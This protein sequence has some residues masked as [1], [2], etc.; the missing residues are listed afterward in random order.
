[1]D[2]VIINSIEKIVSLYNEDFAYYNDFKYVNWCDVNTWD[3]KECQLATKE[4]INSYFNQPRFFKQLN[5]MD[6]AEEVIP[7]LSEQYDIHIVTLGY[8]PN[9]RLKRI[10]VEQHMP[11]VK[12]FIGLGIDKHQDKSC[13]DMSDGISIDDRSD[14][15]C[16]CNADQCICFGDKYQWN[17]QW[18]G[19][20]AANWYDVSRL[21][22][23]GE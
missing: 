17:D 1:M 15:L 11:Y 10:W 8:R 7:L 22:K 9:L 5:F 14:N 2:G 19:M 21:I 6:N 13:I 18:S 4:Y 12:E 23:G 16:T 20:R 3:F